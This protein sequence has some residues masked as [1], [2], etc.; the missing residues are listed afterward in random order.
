M[1]SRGPWP[2]AFYFYPGL[3]FCLR[4]RGREELGDWL[5]ECVC[6]MSTQARGQWEPSSYHS[7]PHT[8]TRLTLSLKLTARLAC[9]WAADICLSLAPAPELYRGIVTEL[10]FYTVLEIQPVNAHQAFYSLSHLPSPCL[11]FL[12]TRKSNVFFCKGPSGILL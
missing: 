5:Y 2:M 7:P 4:E 9:H 1:W 3:L 11:S 12:L 10:R 6:C 8:F